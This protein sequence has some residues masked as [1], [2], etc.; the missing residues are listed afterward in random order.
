MKSDWQSRK[1]MATRNNGHF[2][3]RLF[4]VVW[5]WRCGGIA[6]RRSRQLSTPAPAISIEGAL[7]AGLSYYPATGMLSGTP[8]CGSVGTYPLTVV[9]SNGAPPD[10]RTALTLTVRKAREPEAS[11]F[12]ARR[13]VP[14]GERESSEGTTVVPRIDL[15]RS[16]R[17]RSLGAVCALASC[18]VGANRA[19]QAADFEV[20][21]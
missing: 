9:A 15:H 13:S 3:S 19:A 4:R 1:W 6:P 21:S 10:A 17:L 2:F 8:A 7:P 5:I 14:D 11:G 20:Q 18:L 16:A 12:V